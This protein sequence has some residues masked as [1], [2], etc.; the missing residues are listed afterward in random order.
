MKS[1]T[2]T[3]NE[4]DTKNNT[5]S[6]WSGIDKM[7][8][9]LLSSI[10]TGQTAKF[11]CGEGNIYTSS[12]RQVSQKLLIIVLKNKKELGTIIYDMNTDSEVTIYARKGGVSQ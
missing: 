8:F 6:H 12:A 1:E 9:E 3:Q 10:V 4:G 2:I 11:K 5:P 7:A